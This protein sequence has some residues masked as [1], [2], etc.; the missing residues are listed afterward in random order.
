MYLLSSDKSDSLDDESNDYG[1]DSGSSGMYYFPV[2]YFHFDDSVG[3]VSV[4][5]SGIFIPIVVESKC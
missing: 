1:S 5:G 3:R 4:L 2:F